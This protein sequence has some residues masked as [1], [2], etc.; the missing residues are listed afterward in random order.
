MFLAFIDYIRVLHFCAPFGKMR[1]GVK[2]R[3]VH[4][5][6]ENFSKMNNFSL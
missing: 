3:R 4:T 6:I 2:Y 1:N 5:D